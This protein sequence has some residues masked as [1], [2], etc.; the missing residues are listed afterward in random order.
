MRS[1]AAQTLCQVAFHSAENK[2]LIVSIGGVPKLVRLLSSSSEDVKMWST[3][4]IVNLAALDSNQQLIAAERGAVAKLIS[5]CGL[6]EST[7]VQQA[8]A[9][10]LSNLAI[11]SR[12]K[13][14]IA[15][16][17]A[18]KPLVALLRSNNVG[19]LQHS[20]G[21][22]ANLASLAG[23]RSMIFSENAVPRLIVILSYSSTSEVR[24]GIGGG[25]GVKAK[26]LLFFYIFPFIFSGACQCLGGFD[27]PGF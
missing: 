25:W 7:A 17:G 26:L 1:N 12:N 27:V 15:A 4:A 20:A 21:A 2:E 18:I 8:A 13:G 9:G 14:P 19:V 16:A 5:L 11:D 10:A 22:L 24:R 6:R 23:N 3:M